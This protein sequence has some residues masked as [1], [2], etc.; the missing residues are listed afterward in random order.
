MRNIPSP[1]SEAVLLHVTPPACP[2]FPARPAQS[3]PSKCAARAP[4]RRSLRAARGLSS[5][6]C[7]G[8]GVQGTTSREP[9]ET[10]LSFFHFYSF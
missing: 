6:A 1:L 9:R 8:S 7:P 4:G 2:P 3:R 10:H 5:F